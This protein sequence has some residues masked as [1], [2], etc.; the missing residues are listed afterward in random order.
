MNKPSQPIGVF[1]SGVGG[2]SVLKH[3]VKILPNEHY[4]YLGDTARVPYGN[5]SEE[6]I[7]EYT[8][9]AVKFLLHHNAK[10]IVIACNTASAIAL[11]EAE[12][13]S[14]SPIIGMIIPAA[15]AASAISKNGKIGVIGTRAT[16]GSKAYPR[17]IALFCQKENNKEVI[18]QACPLFVPLAEEGFH[19]HPSAEL[20]IKEYLSPL[21]EAGIDTLVLGCTHY[22][23]LAPLIQRELP[24]VILIDCGEYAAKEAKIVLTDLNLLAN[25][26][27]NSTSTIKFYLTD[28][29]P[30]FPD[31]AERFLGFPI[32]IP[33]RITLDY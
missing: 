11:L 16:I 14:K 13:L 7:K 30:L 3:L 9:Q 8:Q 1:D 2:L 21:R 33:E 19:F 32:P 12:S 29:T 23:L 17:T 24:N 15:K 26:Y 5:K 20:I 18:G 10:L 31:I 22:P 25:N 6:T 28:S 27:P 4:I